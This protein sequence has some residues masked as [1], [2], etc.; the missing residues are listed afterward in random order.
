MNDT[1][2]GLQNLSRREL[3][4]HI[5]RVTGME[6]FLLWE[7]VAYGDIWGVVQAGPEAAARLGVREGEII[8]Y[9][10]QGE[11]PKGSAIGDLMHARPQNYPPYPDPFTAES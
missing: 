9:V 1:L 2:Q 10:V 3:L 5:R 11:R 8:G 7:N 6:N 4:L